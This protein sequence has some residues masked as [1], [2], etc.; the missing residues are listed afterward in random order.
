MRGTWRCGVALLC[1]AGAT[2]TG[3]LGP[4][5]EALAQ[6]GLRPGDE[7]PE[8]EEFPPEQPPPTP[9]ELPPIPP[10]PEEEP[11]S[12]G[13]AVP[14]RGFA[15]EGSTVFTA[16]ELEAV[17]APYR[18][19]AITSEELLAARDAITRHYIERGYVTSGAVIPDQ[20]VEDGTVRIQVVEGKLTDVRV[21]GTRWFRP[22][23]FRD[24]LLRVG[25]A[26]LSVV[27]LE[28]Q[29]QLFQRD[30]LVERVNARLEPG[31]GPGE[32][33]LELVVEEGR[34]YSL[35]AE[36]T[37]DHSPS[38]G[39]L[40]GVFTVELA[41][42]I[43]HADELTGFFDVTEGLF[44]YDLRY[45][46]PLNSYDTRLHLRFRDTDS[47]VVEEPF[48]ALGISST[49]RT[50][51]LALEHP[52]LRTTSQELW[53]SLTGERRSSEACVSIFP[54][55]CDPFAFLPGTTDPEQV[56][57]VFRLIQDW[58]WRSPADVVAAR[59][60]ASLGVD[61]LGA[62]VSGDSDAPDSEYFAWLGQ[63]QWAH[64]FPER[65]LRSQMVAR[66]DIQL[67]TSPLLSVEKFAIGGL[68]SVRGYRKNELVRD[69]GVAASVEVRVPIFRGPLGRE[70]VQLVPF[71]DIGRGWDE[72]D[73]LP[74]RTL[75]SL[76]IG[77]RVAPFEWLVGELYWGAQLK[78]VPSPLED[79]L[80]DHGILFRLVV[81]PFDA[82]PQLWRR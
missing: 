13:L 29:L 25:R 76:G 26:P 75:I 21:E 30:P 15:V 68:R 71:F 22:R 5:G 52:L 72:R 45:E 46:L 81:R 16:E 63:V 39:A 28:E 49:S 62:T 61:L 10:A 59:S 57:S 18:G 38:I 42:L 43:G 37:N 53:L 79:D 19:R 6:I 34:P 77:V 36:F 20:V 31:A 51:A 58:T 12:A 69:N 82:F 33:V 48:D 1:L 24:R 78:D 55:E 3:A 4:A 47:D 66:A 17:T 80:Q 44:D 65:L 56:V 60:T 74:D 41:N 9:L 2:L 54:P 40:G 8:L 14:I 64:R 23:Y 11:L 35:G 7:K 70:I 73:D 27:R 32:S 50:Y 67:A